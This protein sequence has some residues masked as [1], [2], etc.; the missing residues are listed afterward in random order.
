MGSDD[1]Y[2]SQQLFMIHTCLLWLFNIHHHH[3]IVTKAYTKKF[4]YIHSISFVKEKYKYSN[5]INIM[6]P[7]EKLAQVVKKLTS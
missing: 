3:F 7:K 2:T 1:Y 6:V 5:Q 4:G